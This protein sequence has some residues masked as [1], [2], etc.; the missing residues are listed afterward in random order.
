M[1]NGFLVQGHAIF[2]EGLRVKANGL[3]SVSATFRGGLQCLREFGVDIQ[4]VEQLVLGHVF[5]RLAKKLSC[6]RGGEVGQSANGGLRSCRDFG[7]GLEL[8]FAL[9]R[10]D[11]GLFFGGRPNHRANQ[12]VGGRLDSQVD[13]T[14]GQVTK[15]LRGLGNNPGGLCDGGLDDFASFEPALLPRAVDLKQFGQL[16]AANVGVLGKVIGRTKSVVVEKGVAVLEVEVVRW[17][18]G[19]KFVGSGLHL[20]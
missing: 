13:G 15:A 5:R 12:F 1:F 4:P 7:G 19:G 16:L 2:R 3:A 8:G 20:L 11:S 14:R 18:Q 17:F 6:A 9:L 10:V